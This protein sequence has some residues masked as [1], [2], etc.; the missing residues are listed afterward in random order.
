MLTI[1]ENLTSKYIT[2]ILG[3]SHESLKVKRRPHIFESD[4]DPED[5]Q[6]LQPQ[7]ID[8]TK[9][10][11]VTDHQLTVS[12]AAPKSKKKL[13]QNSP[14]TSKKPHSNTVLCGQPHARKQVKNQNTVLIW[15][16]SSCDTLLNPLNK[17]LNDLPKIS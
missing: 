6:P 11:D 13:C 16:H 4:T 1:K 9:E 15:G 3:K 2:Q 7:S 12:R 8:Q 5:S 17:D 14:K 10:V